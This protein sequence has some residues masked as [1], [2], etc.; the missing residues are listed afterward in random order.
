MAKTAEKKDSFSQDADGALVIRPKFVKEI[1]IAETVFYSVVGVFTLTIGLGI[2]ALL[3]FS[4]LQ[5]TRIIPMWL[6]FTAIFAATAIVLPPYIYD[7]IKK[8][9][10]RS[11]YKFL[12]DHILFQHFVMLFFRQRGR[13]KYN[14]I[15]D[16]IERANVAQAYFGIGNVWILAPGTGLAAS[17]RFPGLKMKSIELTDELTDFFEA[18]LFGAPQDTPPTTQTSG[19]QSDDGRQQQDTSSGKPSKNQKGKAKPA[20]KSSGK[21]KTAGK[22]KSANKG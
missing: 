22:R 20:G 3:V 16:V 8:N 11:G 17:Q 15:Q 1:A 14:D 13:V 9:M 5:L 21:A 18:V 2:I 10:A 12:D 19:G 6:P 4:L 7:T